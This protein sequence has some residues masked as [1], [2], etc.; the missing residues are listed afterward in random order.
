MHVRQ[1]LVSGVGKGRERVF[2]R[3]TC[4]AD[5]LHGFGG[6]QA[7]ENDGVGDVAVGLEEFDEDG[8]GGGAEAVGYDGDVLGREG[9]GG[10]G[11]GD[12]RVALYRGDV[13]RLGSEVCECDGG[14]EVVGVGG[15]VEVGPGGEVCR[16][17][18]G[19][20]LCF[21]REVAGEVVGG[22]V[23]VVFGVVGKSFHEEGEERVVTI[24]VGAVDVGGGEEELEEVVAGQGG[25]AAVA[26]EVDDQSSLALRGGLCEEVGSYLGEDCGLI[27][28][29]VESC[30][31]VCA[32][33]GKVGDEKD[34][35]V[36]IV[37]FVQIV[38]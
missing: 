4:A 15:G 17:L 25:S 19:V 14:G 21:P 13:C 7:A 28:R 33:G 10:E 32:V 24:A 12:V 18:V 5:E 9:W 36:R 11:G 34:C 6:G 3:A 8:A 35:R 38:A 16:G 30:V 1:R 27:V 29:D 23:V 37:C 26:A 20:K 2:L 22:S 31:W